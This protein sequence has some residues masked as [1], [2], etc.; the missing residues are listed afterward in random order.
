MSALGKRLIKAAKNAR[1]IA[2]GEGRTKGL[3]ERLTPEQRAQLFAFR[4][5]EASGDQTLPK[6]AAK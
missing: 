5:H 4:G 6:R 2:R 3:L 1:K